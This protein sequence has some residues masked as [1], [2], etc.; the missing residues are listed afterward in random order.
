MLKKHTMNHHL[1][2]QF[3]ILDAKKL[4]KVLDMLKK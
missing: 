2:Q 1:N 3:W 4:K